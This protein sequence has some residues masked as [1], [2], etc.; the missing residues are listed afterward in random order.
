MQD[1]L[2]ILFYIRKS[3]AQDSELGTIYLRITYSGER[4]ELSTFLNFKREA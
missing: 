1:L 3:K 2:S 4:A